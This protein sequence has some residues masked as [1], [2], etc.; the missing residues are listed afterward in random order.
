MRLV[1]ACL[2][3]AACASP[4]RLSASIYQHEQRANTLAALG[5]RDA[6]RAEWAAAQ[7]EREAAA[8]KTQGL[9]TITYF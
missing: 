9:E 8:H 2:A 3:L 1:I 4:Q 7:R 6:A 5:K